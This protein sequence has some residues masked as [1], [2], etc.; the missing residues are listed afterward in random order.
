[1][2]AD[3]FVPLLTECVG[4]CNDSTVVL[5]SLR[6][7]GF[8]LRMNLPSVPLCAKRLGPYILKLLTDAGAASNSRNEISQACFKTLTLL[9]NFGS[10]VDGKILESNGAS[11]STTQNV[12]SALP[13]DEEQMQTLVSIIYAA[14][15]DFE[16]NNATFSLIKTLSSKQYISPEYYDLMD[17]ILKL[18]VQ[19]QKV[20][21]RQV[22]KSNKIL[23]VFLLFT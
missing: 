4:K 9:M 10:A 17:M 2:M 18:S 23:N 8:F 7:L 12:A 16:H 21:V 14:V 13:L 6:C 20:T 3:P 5:L 15:S 19:C 22:R 11:F 1:M